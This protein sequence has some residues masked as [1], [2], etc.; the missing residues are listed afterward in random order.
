MS[1]RPDTSR[2]E[3]VQVFQSGMECCLN[4][5][6]LS[7][8]GR[9]VLVTDR[10]TGV[11]VW[12]RITNRSVAFPQQW[13]FRG[14]KFH[15]TR[16]LAMLFGNPGVVLLDVSTFQTTPCLSSQN[17]FDSDLV[18]VTDST[19]IV[20]T[21]GGLHP[22]Y[23]GYQFEGV[24]LGKR[25]RCGPDLYQNW[26]QRHTRVSPSR[27]RFAVE[28][29][30]E[31]DPGRARYEV[32]IRDTDSGERVATVH[33][34]VS[35]LQAI[36]D[37]HTLLFSDRHGLFTWNMSR[38]Q[39]ICRLAVPGRNSDDTHVALSGDGSKL[40]AARRQTVY[41]ID[42]ATMRVVRALDFPLKA[43]IHSVAYS[44]DGLT[45]AFGTG[46]RRFVLWDLE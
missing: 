21:N 36:L 42:V 11:E 45:A 33:P 7:C 8:D 41:E 17:H 35:H 16:P 13:N 25:W 46:K 34:P 29:H 26:Q 31:L 6:S 27:E 4:G 1:G 10:L 39:E 22:R 38:G 2:G 37:D 19:L 44:P 28:G 18:F 12:D 43:L 32:E 24:E 5:L 30:R 20:K 9:F 3:L 23:F 14:G 15:P 40:V